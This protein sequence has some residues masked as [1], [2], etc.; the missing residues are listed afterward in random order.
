MKNP[1][2][3]LDIEPKYYDYRKANFVV[4]P[5]P[6]ELTTTYGKG[7]KKGPAA[8]LRASQMVENFDEELQYETCT[9]TPIYTLKPCGIS[10]LPSTIENCST[11]RKRR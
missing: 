4:I 7:T 3:F 6:H 5:V 9:K 11:I 8:I 10:R 1:S 2:R